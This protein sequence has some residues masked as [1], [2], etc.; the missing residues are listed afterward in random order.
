MDHLAIDLPGVSSDLLEEL[1]QAALAA[2][3]GRLALVGGVVRDGLLHYQQGRP[4]TG[5][6]DLDLVVE[7]D[8]AAVA[9]VLKQRCGSKRLTRCL[10]HASFAT[11]AL[12]LDGFALDLA[13]AR[14]ETYPAP[15]QNPVVQPGSL[16]SD[17][18]R[19]DFT[20]N[21]M[22]L[23]LLSGEL[24]DRHDG[25]THLAERQLVFLH[26]AS[27]ADDPTR[28]IR[29]ARYGARLG[30]DFS[31]EALDQAQSTL[32]CWPWSWHP[33]APADQ[34][35]PALSTRLRMELD[36]LLDHE[37]WQQGLDRLDRWGAL[38]LIDP[39]LQRDPQRSRRLR[40][41]QRL[42]VPLLPAL[43]TAADRPL[44]TAQRLQLS[45]MQLSWLEQ[46]P[47]LRD[48]AESDAPPLDASPSEWTQALE[49]G[50]WSA[51]TV[52]LLISEQ[53]E[54]WRPL[55]RWWGRW[56]H[57]RASLAARDLLAAGWVPGPALGAELQRLRM[58]ELDQGR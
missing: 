52:A 21:A 11:V 30:F 26:P 19:R 58:L 49:T 3:S 27:V 46:L 34:S 22:A 37:P 39:G 45:G 55:L 53:P 41:A 1:R 35:P 9:S 31:P 14:A 25:Q 44:E 29:A 17:L 57:R 10:E 42:S 40:W 2:G 54:N 8:A 20:I 5:V 56:R 16:E 50:G 43:L 32:A 12:T 15:A 13:T 4:W 23:D 33:G 51:G 48:W 24:I 18:V 36:R 28:L 6:T 7:G 47:S 38:S